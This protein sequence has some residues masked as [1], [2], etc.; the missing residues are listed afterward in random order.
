[1]LSQT[2]SNYN[3]LN[4]ESLLRRN[5]YQKVKIFVYPVHGFL[6]YN[7]SFLSIFNDYLKK[8]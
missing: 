7:D 1:M 4:S 6:F 8:M 5:L 2:I 3:F